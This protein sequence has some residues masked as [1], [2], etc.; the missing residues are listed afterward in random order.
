M[1]VIVIK[2]EIQ[3]ILI[4]K[5]NGMT[6]LILNETKGE[7]FVRKTGEMAEDLKDK[8]VDAY[9]DVKNSLT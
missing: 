4:L 5:I 8:V 2:E 1:I 9:N 6:L 3:G 7:K